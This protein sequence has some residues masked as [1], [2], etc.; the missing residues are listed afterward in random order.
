MMEDNYAMNNGGGCSEEEA[1]IE[2]EN[3]DSC[4]SEEEIGVD[5]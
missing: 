1:D 3:K 2:E 5:L 4:G